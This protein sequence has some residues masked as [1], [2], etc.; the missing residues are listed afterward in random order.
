MRKF[1]SGAILAAA[2]VLGFQPDARANLIFEGLTTAGG[3][4]VNNSDPAVA[5]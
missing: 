2:T 5:G 4:G 3:T 1:L